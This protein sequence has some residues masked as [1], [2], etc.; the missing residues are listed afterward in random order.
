M[1]CTHHRSAAMSPYEILSLA[2]MT[3]I[4]AFTAFQAGKK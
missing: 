2:I 1:G 3:V 4:L